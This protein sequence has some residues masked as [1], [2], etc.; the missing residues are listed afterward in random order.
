MKVF[1]NG[2]I[3]DK[4]HENDDNTFQFVMDRIQES[5]RDGVYEGYLESYPFYA[6]NFYIMEV[7]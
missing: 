1:I 2:F 5:M 3:A 7:K 6:V 4:Q